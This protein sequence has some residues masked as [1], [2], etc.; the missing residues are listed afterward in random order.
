MMAVV[1][2]TQCWIYVGLAYVVG[3]VLQKQE[4]PA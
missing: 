1:A 3:T 2:L 4:G